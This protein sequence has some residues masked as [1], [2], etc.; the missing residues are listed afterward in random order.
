MRN[1]SPYRI[2]TYI[3]KLVVYLKSDVFKNPLTSVEFQY[4]VQV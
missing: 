4:I 1:F 3:N 2:G